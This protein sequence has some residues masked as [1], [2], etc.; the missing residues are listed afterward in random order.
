MNTDLK[1]LREIAT[2]ATPGPWGPWGANIP[3]YIT[4]EKPAPSL[5][6]YDHER[7]NYWRYEDGLFFLY[8]CPK[9]ALELLD[10][11]ERLQEFERKYKD[12][13]E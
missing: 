13:N 2:K 7:A 12:L 8:F 3:F 10:E 4:V 6:K 9:T 1:E 5:S 11:I